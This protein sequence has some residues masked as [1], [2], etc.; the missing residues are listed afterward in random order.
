MRAWCSAWW[1]PRQPQ[2]LL[3][4]ERRGES[5]HAAHFSGVGPLSPT[6]S[7]LRGAREMLSVEA[8]ERAQRVVYRR[9]V[10]LRRTGVDSSSLWGARGGLS[11][12]PRAEGALAVGLQRLEVDVLL[13]AV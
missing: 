3:D 10:R 11:S 12:A 4:G 6:L 7:T 13:H 1:W 8:P 2:S 9:E 5:L